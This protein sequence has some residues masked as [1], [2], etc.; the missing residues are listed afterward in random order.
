MSENDILSKERVVWAAIELLDRVGPKRFGMRKLARTLGVYPTALYWHIDGGINTLVA[1]MVSTVLSNRVV[2]QMEESLDWKAWLWE[3]FHNWRTTVQ[4]HPHIVS[5]VGGLASNPGRG[6][7][8][9]EAILSVL[10]RAGFKGQA[11]VDAYNTV[12]AA[13]VGF[14]TLEF[15][16]EPETGQVEWV[17]A[18]REQIERVNEN[19]YPILAQHKAL[20][21]NRAFIVRWQN[22]VA[23]PLTGAFDFYVQVV[24]DGL[25]LQLGNRAAHRSS[26]K[27]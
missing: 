26:K 14:P 7:R 21:A 3:L 23:S 20:M 22:G 24:V 8:M 10:E 2:P 12:V 13:M 6:F 19:Q 16:P 18:F 11:L 15:A 1:E 5:L 27:D 25:E 9:V 17:R 4:Q